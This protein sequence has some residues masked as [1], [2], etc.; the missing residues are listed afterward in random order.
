MKHRSQV[1]SGNFIRMYANGTSEPDAEAFA[2][3][4]MRKYHFTCDCWKSY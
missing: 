1:I 4:I 2:A 3:G